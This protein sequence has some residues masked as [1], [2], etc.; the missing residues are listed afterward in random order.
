MK[1]ELDRE[2]LLSLVKGK[3]P[4]YSVFEEPIVKKN[5]K[6]IGGHVDKWQWGNIES[7]SN[8]ELFELYTIC[9]NSWK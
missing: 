1:V 7:L 6:W 2:D 9:K 8:E 5:G 3:T 4:Y